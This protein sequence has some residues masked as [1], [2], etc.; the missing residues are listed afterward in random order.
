M[1]RMVY[2]VNSWPEGGGDFPITAVRQGESDEDAIKRAQLS[3]SPELE[4]YIKV[5]ETP[6]GQ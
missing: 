3:Y 5:E 6:E 4:C 2:G 1:K